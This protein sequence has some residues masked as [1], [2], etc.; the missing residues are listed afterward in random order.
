MNFF[1]KI[2]QRTIFLS[3]RWKGLNFRPDDYDS[4]TLPTELQRYFFISTFPLILHPFYRTCRRV[5][6]PRFFSKIIYLRQMRGLG[7]SNFHDDKHRYSKR[8]LSTMSFNELTEP[9]KGFKPLTLALQV[10]YSNQTELIRLMFF[11][12]TS[13]VWIYTNRITAI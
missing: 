12:R 9:N 7:R 5:S 6:T 1:F 3:Y 2:F 4:S 8:Q 10:R 13:S 11:L